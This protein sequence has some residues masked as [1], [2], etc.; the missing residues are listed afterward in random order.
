MH[1]GLSFEKLSNFRRENKNY[2]R[3]N[4]LF[5]EINKKTNKS[6]IKMKNKITYDLNKNVK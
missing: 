5:K 4:M 2:I 6:S 3:K 1:N